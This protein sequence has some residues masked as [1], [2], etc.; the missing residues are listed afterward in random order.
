MSSNCYAITWR[1]W[2]EIDDE[3]WNDVGGKVIVAFHVLLVK[4]YIDY[5]S[6]ESYFVQ[7]KFMYWCCHGSHTAQTSL[8][9]RRVSKIWAPCQHCTLEVKQLAIS[10]TSKLVHAHVTSDKSRGWNII[11]HKYLSRSIHDGNY[12]LL[13]WSR[14]IL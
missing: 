7:Y 2:Y 14:N 8:F 13:F 3:K 6:F 10:I 4:P 12:D 11:N 5:T 1:R 9:V